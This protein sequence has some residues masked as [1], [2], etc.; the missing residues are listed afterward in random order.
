[1]Q[2]RAYDHYLVKTPHIDQLATEGLLFQ[3]AYCN[4]PLCAPSRA[5][6]MTGLYPDQ[7]GL[8]DLN[9]LV[10]ER[11]PD[12]V[13]MPQTFMNNG[14]MSARVGKLYHYGNPS[15]IGTPGAR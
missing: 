14:Y 12:V 1:L 11:V 3:N 9:T 15:E 5:S 13:T 2:Y 10:R 8:K 6:M 4:F 7:T